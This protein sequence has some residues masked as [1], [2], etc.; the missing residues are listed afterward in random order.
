M[1]PPRIHPYGSSRAHRAGN[2]ER[3]SCRPPCRKPQSSFAIRNILDGRHGRPS[4]VLTRD[5]AKPQRSFAMRTILD[6]RH[7]RPSQV[8]TRD[9]AKPQRSF[10]IRNILDGRHGRPSQVRT[11]DLANLKGRSPCPPFWTADTAVPPGCGLA[12][13]G[14]HAHPINITLP[15]NFRCGVNDQGRV[16]FSRRLFFPYLKTSSPHLIVDG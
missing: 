5:L 12:T 6:G 10:A 9:L 13:I 11:R 8:P 2:R 3:R 7:G 15:M 4:R 16:V 14:G 1:R